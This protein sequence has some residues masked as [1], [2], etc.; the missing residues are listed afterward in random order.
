MRLLQVAAEESS[1]VERYP[2][3]YPE[4]LQRVKKFIPYIY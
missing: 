3:E 4:Y 2:S 1:L